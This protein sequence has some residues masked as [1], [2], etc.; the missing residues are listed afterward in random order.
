MTAV[1]GGGGGSTLASA[2]FCAGLSD[3]ISVDAIDGSLV[4]GLV[5]AVVAVGSGAA[6]SLPGAVPVVLDDAVD[7]R[8]VVPDPPLAGK[9]GVDV[10]EV[11]AGDRIARIRPD[12]HLECSTSFV[13]LLLPGIQNS[14]VV[15]RLR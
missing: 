10:T 2:G 1:E 4:T 12:R 9:P 13:V 8:N 7:G 15:V 5:A 6:D 11:F 3:S 14:Q